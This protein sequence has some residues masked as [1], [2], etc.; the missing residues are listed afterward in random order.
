MPCYFDYS[1]TLVQIEGYVIIYA[2][3]RCSIQY[4]NVVII[5]GIIATIMY[6]VY[7]N[8]SFYLKAIT[9]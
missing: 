2:V 9:S 6:H 1:D 8:A 5:I 4:R 7:N 3:T